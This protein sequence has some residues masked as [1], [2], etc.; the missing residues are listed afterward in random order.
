MTD[1]IYSHDG[2]ETSQSPSD[3]VAAL[4]HY[5]LFTVILL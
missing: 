3:I 2:A 5:S 4:M 1:R